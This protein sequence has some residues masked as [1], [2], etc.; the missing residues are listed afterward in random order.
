[1]EVQCC[2]QVCSWLCS[3]SGHGEWEEE[4]EFLRGPRIHLMLHQQRQGRP[5]L[6]KTEQLAAQKCCF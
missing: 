6:A 2:F 1:M 5:T 3:Q 4:G